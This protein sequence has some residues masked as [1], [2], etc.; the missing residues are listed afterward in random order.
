VTE[1]RE[2]DRQR[3]DF[4]TV[5]AHELRT[6]LTP[7]SMYL[8]SI[9]RRLAR[10]QPVEADLVNKARRQVERLG[11][12]VEDLLDVSRLESRRI[13]VG[14][15]DVDLNA[16]VDA[17]VADFRAQTRNHDIVFQRAAAAILVLG[18][19]DRLEQV[20]VNLLN[21]AIKY[22]PQGGQIVVS[23]GRAA[24]EARVSV[25]D[26]GIGIPKAEHPRL[27]QRFFRA[28]NATTRN[29]SGLGIGLFVS[30]EIIKRHGGRFEVQSDVGAG[31]TFTFY[32]PLSARARETSGARARV[33]LVDDDP[34][35]LE[36]TGQLLREWGYAVDEARDGQTALSIARTAEPDLM[37]IDLMMP[38]MDGWTLIRRLRDE[39]VAL[40][41]PVVV[42]SADRD[43]RDKARHLEADAA[44]RKPF[45]LQELQD[46]LERLLPPKPAA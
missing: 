36:A 11:K 10:G 45:E 26:P 25:K 22:S 46:V 18:D 13:Q 20:L 19:E 6:P 40:Q 1:Q 7:L 14:A 37:L 15:L 2:L 9:E 44:L 35:I 27:F 43:A 5:A 4:L 24:A 30:S 21:N 17:V 16:L 8:Q 32:L 38:V 28:A 42:F 31:S 29:Y 12:L 39:K 33:L 34:E 41:V 3:S 23:L